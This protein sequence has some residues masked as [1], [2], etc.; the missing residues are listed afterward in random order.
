[1]NPADKRKT[2]KS[3]RCSVIR[4]CNQDSVLLSASAS[5]SVRNK[6]VSGTRCILAYTESL[7]TILRGQR[8]GHLLPAVMV[9]DVVL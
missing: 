5:I 2:Q 1:M 9:L 3:Q 8:D 7:W 6:K 4:K